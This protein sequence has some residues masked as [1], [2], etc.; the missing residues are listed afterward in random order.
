V[1]AFLHSTQFAPLIPGGRARC[2]RRGAVR[3]LDP[4]YLD[5]FSGRLRRHVVI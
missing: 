3:A 5:L 2:T 1:T 4:A